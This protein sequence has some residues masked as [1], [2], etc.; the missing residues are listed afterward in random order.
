MFLSEYGLYII[1]VL[2]SSIFLHNIRKW[3]YDTSHFSSDHSRCGVD[4]RQYG[5]GNGK[6]YL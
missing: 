1:T 3:I 2:K 6:A 5:C 4:S